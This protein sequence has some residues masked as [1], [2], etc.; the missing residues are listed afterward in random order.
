MCL[1]VTSL[2]V[3]HAC[4]VMT[5][6]GVVWMQGWGGKGMGRGLIRLVG[7]IE[8]SVAIRGELTVRLRQGRLTMGGRQVRKA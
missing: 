1:G 3:W 8:M 4:E 6:V 2:Q 5:N 7:I